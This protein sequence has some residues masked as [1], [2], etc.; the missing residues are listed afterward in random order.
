[1][2]SE[3]GLD[4]VLKAH[5]HHKG[6]IFRIYNLILTLKNT[7]IDKI[8]TEWIGELGIDI[9]KDTW[10]KAVD[11]INRTSSCA[12]LSLIQ[13]KVFYRIHYSKTKLAKIYPN[14][15]ETCDRCN[16]SKQG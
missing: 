2:P 1:M 5:I 13:M 14:T 6:L 7:S 11:R 15:D 9:S 4:L 16:A 3:S 8:K 12:R 10:D